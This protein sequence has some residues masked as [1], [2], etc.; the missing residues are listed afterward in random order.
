MAAAASPTALTHL[1]QLPSANVTKGRTRAKLRTSGDKD[2]KIKQI[3]RPPI[4][5]SVPAVLVG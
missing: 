4:V 2:Q 3:S 5:G 1:I